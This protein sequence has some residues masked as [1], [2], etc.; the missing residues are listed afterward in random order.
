[1]PDMDGITATEAIRRKIPYA[2]VVILSVQ[3]DA[4]YMQRRHASWGTRLSNKATFN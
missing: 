3:S 4:H 1:M 2:Q